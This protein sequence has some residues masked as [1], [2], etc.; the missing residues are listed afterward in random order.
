M[1]SLVVFHSEFI[2]PSVIRIAAPRVDQLWRAYLKLR[3][4]E[5]HISVFGGDRGIASLRTVDAQEIILDVAQMEPSLPLR[6]ID[7]VIGLSRPQ[8]VKKVIQTAVMTGVRSLHLLQTEHGEKSYGTSHLLE[9]DALHDETIKALEQIGEGLSPAIS[10]HRSFAHFCKNGLRALT[11]DELTIKILAHPGG[12]SLA[13][14][15]QLPQ[16][17]VAVVAV[18]P[19]PGWSVSELESFEELGFTRVGLGPRVMRVEIALSFLLGQLQVL[20]S[21]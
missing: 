5:I 18:G 7:L 15:A 20:S 2:G 13:S 21:L 16:S 17:K 14:V 10:I 1:N 3:G 8:T 6:P 12:I 11:S 9:A 19:E 4:Q